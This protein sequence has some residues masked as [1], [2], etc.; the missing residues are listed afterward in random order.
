M[1]DLDDAFKFNDEF[2]T[3]SKFSEVK[4]TCP[5]KRRPFMDK[6]PASIPFLRLN[7][8]KHVCCYKKDIP[9]RDKEDE[10]P[11]NAH[12]EE[13][14]SKEEQPHKP[15]A[16]PKARKAEPKADTISKTIESL[17]H[18][19]K[20]S[21]Q[22]HTKKVTRAFILRTFHPDKLPITI[23]DVMKKEQLAGNNSAS[24]F[25]SRVFAKVSI[26]TTLTMTE[27]EHILVD[28]KYSGGGRLA[29][30]R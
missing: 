26:N 21:L 7:P 28:T 10:E 9:R 8:Q 20:S 4:T 11:P 3:K 17:K 29:L 25:A 23:K 24:L 27:L 12:K 18:F 2:V 14:S 19:Y 5:K 22:D 16:A 13:K 15:K 30:L 1:Y 6:C